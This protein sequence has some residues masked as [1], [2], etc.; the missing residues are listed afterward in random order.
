MSSARDDK[1]I[2]QNDWTHRIFPQ[3]T[4]NADQ[5]LG[6]VLEYE[7]TPAM[8]AWEDFTAYADSNFVSF[9][10]DGYDPCDP[11]DPNIPSV[12]YYAWYSGYC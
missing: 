12:L 4:A 1:Q 10:V 6:Q 5:E 2:D 3:N 9:L 7:Q 8:T 11:H